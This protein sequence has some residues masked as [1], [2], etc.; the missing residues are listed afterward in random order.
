M[1]A[2]PGQVVQDLTGHVNYF[3]NVRYK[4]NNFHFLLSHNESY[5]KVL[6]ED[7]CGCYILKANWQLC[8][9]WV[10]QGIK[11]KDERTVGGLLL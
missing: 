7:Y 4:F 5:L 11:I 3:N 9:E 6:A 2:D 1:K 8:V 10:L